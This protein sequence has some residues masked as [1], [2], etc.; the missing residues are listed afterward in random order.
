MATNIDWHSH[1]TAPEI[2]DRIKDLN[3]QAAAYRRSGFARFFQAH[4]GNG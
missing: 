1:H 4:Q 2:S 3:R